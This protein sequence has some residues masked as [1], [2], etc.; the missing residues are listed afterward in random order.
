MFD[1]LIKQIYGD[2]DTSIVHYEWSGLTFPVLGQG[3]GAET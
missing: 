1:A 3:L 2:W